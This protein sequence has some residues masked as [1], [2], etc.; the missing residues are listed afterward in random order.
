VLKLSALLRAFPHASDT[1]NWRIGNTDNAASSLGQTP[2][3]SP[4]VFNFYR[5]GYV[6]PGTQS[7]NASLVAPELQIAHE[8][9][10]AGY[11]NYMRDA[12][13][14]GVGST[15]AA[16]NN[17]RD[18]QPNYSAELALADQPAAL[19]DRIAAKLTYGTAPAALKTEITDAIS[20]I[21]IPAATGSNQAAIDTA[22]RNRVN[23]ALLLVLASPEFQVQK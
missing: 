16:F 23:A 18:V 22:K 15:N 14:L 12:V 20:K 6:A 17:R 21:T 19:V 5:P 4:S 2:M 13:S 8:T 9:S 11:T 3:R 1:G 7:A 10:A